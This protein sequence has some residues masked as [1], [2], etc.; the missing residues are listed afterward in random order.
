METATRF[1]C[2]RPVLACEFEEFSEDIALN[3]VLKAAA[4]VV[5]R[6]ALLPRDCV[7]VRRWRWRA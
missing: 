3:R 1:Y 4:H 7:A 2:G 5:A 6:S